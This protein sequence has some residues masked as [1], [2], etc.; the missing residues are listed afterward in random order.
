LA[1][2]GGRARARRDIM[3]VRIGEFPSVRREPNIAA[4]IQGIAESNTVVIS[5][6]TYRLV[7]GYCDCQVSG[8][9]SL[10]GV[11]QPLTTYRVLQESS[12]QSRLDT[13]MTR[14]LTPLIGRES[15]NLA[16]DNALL[17]IS[18]APLGGDS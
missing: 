13:A 3:G 10:K 12:A 16:H 11:S 2:A 8:E 14:G 17:G 9:Y 15:K 7:E 1:K 6:G 18:F 4:R 5:A